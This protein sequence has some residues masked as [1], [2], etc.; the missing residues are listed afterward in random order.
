MA[1]H[2]SPAAGLRFLAITS[3]ALSDMGNIWAHDV[4]GAATQE[5]T[6]ASRA[7]HAELRAT[8][9]SEPQ[10]RSVLSNLRL[11]STPR[12]LTLCFLG[13]TASLRK[14]VIDDATSSWPLPQ[15]TEDRLTFD[16]HSLSTLPDCAAS[17][18]ADIKIS[19]QAGGG[20]WSYVGSESA[21]H[22]PSM[23]FDR[24]DSLS[25]QDARKIVAHEFGHALGLEHEH[26]S[27][28][29]PDCGWNF[30]YILTRYQWRDEKHMKFNF[31]RLQNYLQ[32]SRPA[33][34]FSAYDKLSV[35][36]YS[37][38]PEAFNAGEKSPCYVAPNVF[39]SQLDKTAIRLA[40]SESAAK[41]RTATRGIPVMLDAAHEAD[42][43]ARLLQLLNAR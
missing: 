1:F 34:V 18:S 22:N 28:I 39:P 33:Y 40:Y 42:D 43:K 16:P 8:P 24:L 38:Q 15:L 37:F 21:L 7:I 41:E 23:N 13:G 9:F 5:L 3:L 4:I 17:P 29:V 12:K 14:Q 11:W 31:E 19:F 2:A 36:H 10:K 30:N 27:P 26:Q 25:R 20:H 6:S 35:M 32:Q